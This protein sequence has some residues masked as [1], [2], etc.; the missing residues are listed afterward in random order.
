MN[1]DA[2]YTVT[3]INETLEKTNLSDWKVGDLVNLERAMKL[4]MLFPSRLDLG[5]HLSHHHVH[6]LDGLRILHVF[7][8]QTAHVLRRLAPVIVSFG[9]L[10]T[11]MV[12]GTTG[13]SGDQ[14]ADEKTQGSNV[15]LNLH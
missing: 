6:L 11:A 1:R 7:F 2:L 9:L 10:I 5:D 15:H 3:A 12:M 14:H 13:Q 8:H 4:A